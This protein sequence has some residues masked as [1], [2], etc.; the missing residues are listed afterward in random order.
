MQTENATVDLVAIE[1]RLL[2]IERALV[3]GAELNNKDRNWL[4]STVAVLLVATSDSRWRFR[5]LEEVMPPLLEMAEERL[6]FAEERLRDDEERLKRRREDAAHY[7]AMV[8]SVKSALRGE[9]V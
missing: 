6:S 1:A 4:I 9:T 7:R 2:D 5:K 8:V 3:A